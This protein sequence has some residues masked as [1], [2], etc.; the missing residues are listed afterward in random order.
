MMKS[1]T[2]SD[3]S[4]RKYSLLLRRRAALHHSHRQRHYIG[5]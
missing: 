4:L 5:V 1:F 2:G 3:K